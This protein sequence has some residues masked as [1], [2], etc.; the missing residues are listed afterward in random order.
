MELLKN[1][2]DRYLRYDFTAIEIHELS[3]RLANKT[4]EKSR[5]MEEKKSVT[6]QYKSKLDILDAE[7][8][9]TSQKVANGYEMRKVD[10]KVDYH[11]P[12]QGQKT[13]TR[14]DTNT[15]TVE[16]MSS[17]EWNLW[18]QDTNELPS[19]LDKI[20]PQDYA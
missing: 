12:K 13:I 10:C 4:Q 8:S 5:V 9:D 15:A 7:L 11:K 3:V 18:N 14:T 16:K 19:T 1:S 2:E 6:S 17:E 20:T